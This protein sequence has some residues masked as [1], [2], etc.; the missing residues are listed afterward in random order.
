MPKIEV[1]TIV[2]KSPSLVYKILKDM[3]KFPQFM[4]DVKQVKI[5]K[6]ISNNTLL[7]EWKIDIDGTPVEWKEEDVFDDKM[8]KINFRMKEGSFKKYEGSW[9][10]RPVSNGT[11][12]QLHTLLEWGV[13]N[14][15]KHIGHVLEKKACRSIGSMLWLIRKRANNNG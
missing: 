8:K 10:L 12:I 11:K 4:S 13:P 1:S 15:E 9:E 2:R 14:M 3:E 7:T 6:K 5:F